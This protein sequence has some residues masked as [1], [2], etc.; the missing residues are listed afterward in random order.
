MANQSFTTA[1]GIVVFLTAAALLLF[2][3]VLWTGVVPRSWEYPGYLS[4]TILLVFSM[5]ALYIR[6]LQQA[7]WFLHLGFI[8]VVASLLFSTGFSYYATF[9]FPI[10]REQFP[11]A[12]R[13][14]LGGPISLML[15]VAMG[16]GLVGNALFFSAT[17][18]ARVLPRWVSI[19]ALAAAAL[20]LLMLPY[21][22]A[23]L[24]GA[25]ALLG[26]GASLV[27]SARKTAA[28]QPQPTG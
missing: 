5:V 9:A 11:D 16:L 4:L 17:L 19:V 23:D 12:V 2:N 24:V 14:V 8:L 28:L 10:L 27:G 1:S 3:A 26:A 18:V 20:S 22:A 15:W 21:N 25:V 13:A 6:H 7:R